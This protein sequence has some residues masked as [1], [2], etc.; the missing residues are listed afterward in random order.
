M[1]KFELVRDAS[2]EVFAERNKKNAPVA[3]IVVDDKY[4][5]KF[6]AN[7]RISRALDI[8]TPDQLS[9]RLGGGQYFFID[10]NLIDFRDGQ[11]NGFVHT[12]ESIG[13]LIETIG[14][15]D[16]NATR[17]RRAARETTTSNRVSLSSV[18]SDTEIQVPTYREGGQFNSRL[19]F[20]WNPF[21]RD[22]H[23]AFELVRLI[24]ANG[25][26]GMTSFL[27][28][29]IPIIN[30][31]EEH[32]EIANRQIQNKVSDKVITRLGMM[33][34]ERATIAECQQIVNHAQARLEAGMQSNQTARETLKEIAN[35]ASP[36]LHLG[37]VYRAA[38]FQ[39]TRLGSQLPSH[40]STFDLYN[41]ATEINT[42][43]AETDKSSSFAVDKIANA[44]VFDR[45]DTQ[46]HAARFGAPVQ[47]SFSDADNAF[48]G[49]LN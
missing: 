28:T 25:M 44:L 36:T 15:T 35:I 2:V 27:N 5:H 18:W 6:D 12:D 47:S 20:A 26:V 37:G 22:V 3:R 33:G 10:D 29:K 8:M 46:Q 32:L 31:W 48:F 16:T 11:Y 19:S 43:T 45:E 23:S 42:H 38:A 7:S 49:K 1:N 21:S 30:R 4:E 39:D 24:C 14:I 13:K 34:T 41:M 17:A 40:L 9:H